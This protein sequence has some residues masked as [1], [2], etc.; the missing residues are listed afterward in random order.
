MPELQRY[1]NWNTDPDDFWRP[2]GSDP[3][4]P[5]VCSFDFAARH[6]EPDAP[7]LRNF[8]AFHAACTAAALERADA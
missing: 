8:D 4:S 5:E 6:G 7:V 3:C 2:L 1:S